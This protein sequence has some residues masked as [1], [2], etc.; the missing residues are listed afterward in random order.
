MFVF[1]TDRDLMDQVPDAGF[2]LR[3]QGLVFVS[4][5]GGGGAQGC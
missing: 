1:P 2:D 5:Q 4:R 3:V